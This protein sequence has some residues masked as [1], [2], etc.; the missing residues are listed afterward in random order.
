MPRAGT[1]TTRRKARSSSTDGEA[2][3][4]D[5]VLHLGPLVELHAAD[6][7]VGNPLPQQ[8]F[9]EGPRLGVGAI[10]DR[11]VPRPPSPL[12]DRAR[13]RFGLLPVL[14][15]VSQ[16][17]AGPLPAV[18]VQLLFAAAPV[19]RDD[20]GGGPENPVGRAVVRLER[21]DARAREV[22]V[23]PE[24]VLD[25]GAPPAVDRLVLVPD[26][27]E[28]VRA[29]SEELDEGVLGTVGVLVLVDQQVADP[30]P[31]RR[32]DVRALAQ[33]AHR[34]GDQ[35]VEVE[36]AGRGELLLVEEIDARDPLPCEIGLRL[37]ESLRRHERVLGV[38][39]ARAHGAGR[40][41]LVGDLQLL[42][43]FLHEGQLVRGV[44]DRE[45]RRQFRG[46][47]VTPQQPQRPGVK[48]SDEGED[49]GSSEQLA[50]ALA[51]LL[52][53][54]VRERDRQ[55]RARIH[56][57]LHQPRQPVRDDARFAGARARQ[58]EQGAFLMQDRLALL[59]VQ[60]RQ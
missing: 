20:A 10:E 17:H 4:R 9:F 24:D 35:V 46:G 21:H 51:H 53:G 54:L 27:A 45:P 41:D 28:R 23:E 60:A 31:L 6:D 56:P 43:G 11:D 30:P 22:L 59:G 55:D 37:L 7:D 36:R 26:G 39:D 52:R 15:E 29:L 58:D 2:Q 57:R 33:E 14:L 50:R 1:L 44:G 8:L 5:R 25:L 40:Q 3:V 42:H 12:G 16:A 49:P 38:R 48:R 19:V 34:A 32:Q 13:D 47:R 18:G